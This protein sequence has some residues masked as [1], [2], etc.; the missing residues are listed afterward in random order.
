MLF[1][2]VLPDVLD[3]LGPTGTLYLAVESRLVPLFQRAFPAAKVGAHA[4]Y[5]VGGR[6]ARTAGFLDDLSGIDLWTPLASLLRE[7]RRDLAAYPATDAY[8]APDP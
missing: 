3:A 6:F 5:D 7:F 8:L 1:G 2:N 4:T